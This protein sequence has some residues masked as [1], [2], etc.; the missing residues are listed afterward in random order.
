MEE[1]V[2][3]ESAT[4]VTA[5][6][7]LAATGVSRD[8]IPV[9]GYRNY[10][11]PAMASKNVGRKPAQVKLLGAEVALFRDSQTG[12]V[13]ALEDRCPHRGALLSQGRIYYPSTLTCSYHG[14]TFDTS[15]K[16]LA[17]LSEGPDCPLAGK[18]QVRTFP[19]EEHRGL[20]WLW[21]GEQT[22]VKLE[23]DLP[24]ELRD[25]T[26]ATFMDVQLWRA[27]W[28][29]VTE[30][31]DG[32]HAPIL[33]RRSMPRTLYMDWVAWRKIGVVEMEDGKGLIFV[34]WNAPETA[35]YPGLGKWPQNAW[36]ETAA[37]K[38]F[39]ARM[40]RGTPMT[41]SDGRQAFVTEDIH[42]PGWRRVRV[43]QRTVFLEWAVPIDEKTTRHF[44][45]DAINTSDL[46]GK[47]E[48][49]KVRLKIWTFRNLIYPTYWKWA[50][51]KKYVGQDKWV[52]EGLKEGPERLQSNDIGIIAWRRLAAKSRDAEG[53][54]RSAAQ[55][56]R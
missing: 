3:M 54:R 1:M 24:P 6:E 45:W 13:H 4:P 2:Q 53:S 39:R 20:V 15:G 47:M 51:N 44:L 56:S 7:K 12:K 17:V 18:V 42:L 49:L 33:H 36:W 50:Y 27:N 22:P 34:S 23:D 11:Y 55:V 41:L 52:L 43:R 48:A 37:R 32:Y 30:N 25:L 38:I 8:Q 9:L 5:T 10:W 21:M 16:L 14:W 26:T 35:E 40:S 19:V 46:R 31:T 28:R 29:I